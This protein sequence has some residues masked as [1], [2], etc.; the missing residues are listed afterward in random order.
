M[1]I[2][3]ILLGADETP[4]AAAAADWA[5]HLARAHAAELDAVE[6]LQVE[7]AE[8]PP[9]VAEEQ[10]RSLRARVQGWMEEHGDVTERM[11]AASVA[12][13]PAHVLPEYAADH[14]VDVV[15]IGAG[16]GSGV[17]KLGLGSL[18][19]GLAHRLHCPVVAVPADAPAGAL[20]AVVVGVDG[21]D[22]AIAALRWA[23]ELAGPFGASVVAVYV[24]TGESETP[25]E[26]GPL[27]QAVR[28]GTID[29]AQLVERVATDPAAALAEEAVERDAGLIVVA[30]KTR[31]SMGGTRLG[32][33]PDKLLH[34]LP[35]PVAVLPYAMVHPDE[36]TEA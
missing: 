17:S 5:A 24:G 6:S 22:G 31:G 9:E 15:V 13:D 32:A 25:V 21:S 20:T 11:V 8:M 34:D 23:E 7:G 33:V 26:R 12:G 36:F 18:A 14:G 28:A 27:E 1:T 4:G 29:A 10:E 16:H 30:A 19:Q 2:S 3:R 35:R